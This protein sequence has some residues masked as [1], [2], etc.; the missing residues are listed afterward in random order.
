MINI[1]L[2]YN[3]G[4]KH[5]RKIMDKGSCNGWTTKGRPCL[6]PYNRCIYH[7]S[8]NVATKPGELRDNL[9]DSK[10]RERLFA[11]FTCQAF[12]P[13]G[14]P[15]KIRGHNGYCHIHDG[16]RV[17]VVAQRS[18]GEAKIARVLQH[19]SLDY[20]TEKTFRECFNPVTLRQFRFDFYVKIQNHVF[21]IEFHGK[22]HY[23]PIDFFGGEDKFHDIVSN[24]QM[25][26]AYCIRSKIPLLIIPYWNFDYINKLII[27][28]INDI[29][30]GIDSKV[31]SESSLVDV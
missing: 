26:I 2:L 24:D 21:L 16:S 12:T 22:Q 3:L 20:K 28:F 15:C 30:K 25:K 1:Y 5:K 8:Q 13:E 17:I 4:L 7:K 19:L 18:S 27:A 29:I 6:I 11:K 10:Y 31:G 14:T 23:S 9:C